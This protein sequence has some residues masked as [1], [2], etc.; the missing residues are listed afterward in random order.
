MLKSG[1]TPIQLTTEVSRQTVGSG[2]EVNCMGSQRAGG[3]HVHGRP[4]LGGGR[5]ADQVAPPLGSG[6]L[7]GRQDACRP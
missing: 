6:Q 1:S 2:A 4:F 3:E 7:P 5:V